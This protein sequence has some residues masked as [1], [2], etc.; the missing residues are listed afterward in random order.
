VTVILNKKQKFCQI[1]T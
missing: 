1:R